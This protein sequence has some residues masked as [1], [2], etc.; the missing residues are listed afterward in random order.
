M[1]DLGETLGT[2]LGATMMV[3]V[4]V[5]WLVLRQWVDAELKAWH[6]RRN[7]RKS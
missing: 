4:S 7:E 3:G 5:V 6:R 1:S 2:A